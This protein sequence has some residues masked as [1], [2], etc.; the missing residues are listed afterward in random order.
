MWRVDSKK[1]RTLWNVRAQWHAPTL[2]FKAVDLSLF[3]DFAVNN[4][5]DGRWGEKHPERMT[6]THLS[7]SQL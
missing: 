7:I 6:H 5:E 2:Y 4:F 3:V 1:A